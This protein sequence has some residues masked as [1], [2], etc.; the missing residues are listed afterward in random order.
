MEN[1]EKGI[2][3]EQAHELGL[4]QERALAGGQ[5]VGVQGDQRVVPDVAEIS[6][7]LDHDWYTP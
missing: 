7:P 5:P 3:V 2:L 6:L 4:M 1:E